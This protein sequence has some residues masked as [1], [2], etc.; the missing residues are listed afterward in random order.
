M[1]V[2]CAAF[3]ALSLA[4]NFW[5]QD[6][7]IVSLMSLSWGTIA[8]RFWRRSSTGLCGAG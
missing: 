3:V 1:R 7:P 4:I 2:L 5:M 6:T 8:G